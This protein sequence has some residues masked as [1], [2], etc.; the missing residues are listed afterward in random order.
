MFKKQQ[1]GAGLGGALVTSGCQFLCKCSDH[2]CLIS[3]YQWDATEHGIG[4]K[5]V[6][7]LL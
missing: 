6:N 5:Y 3:S 1:S 7:L 2:P 4:K